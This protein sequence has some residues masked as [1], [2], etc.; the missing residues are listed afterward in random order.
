MSIPM[1]TGG[2]SRL[3]ITMKLAL[4]LALPHCRFRCWVFPAI[5]SGFPCAPWTT[6]S[7]GFK[8][9]HWVLPPHRESHTGHRSASVDKT[10]DWNALEVELGGDGWSYR[11][12]N[13][14]HLGLSGP[15]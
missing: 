2:D 3:M 5:W 9:P 6:P 8:G 4:P 14:G 1:S 12:P 15:L 7:K 13:R 10:E 11:T